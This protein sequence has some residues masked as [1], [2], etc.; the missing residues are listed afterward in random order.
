[1]TARSWIEQIARFGYA[2]KGWCTLSSAYG[3]RLA[4][5]AKRLTGM[6]PS[7]NSYA[8]VPENYGVVAVGLLP[9]VLA[10]HKHS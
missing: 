4:S 8:A 6:V 2:A 5:A 1:M 3:W 9:R 7:N 10:F